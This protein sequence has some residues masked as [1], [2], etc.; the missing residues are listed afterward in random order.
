MMAFI[1]ANM[2]MVVMAIGW[3][4]S[5]IVAHLPNAKSSSAVQLV[6]SLLGSAVDALRKALLPAA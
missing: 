2:G 6:V 1:Q 3:G 5:E 4:V